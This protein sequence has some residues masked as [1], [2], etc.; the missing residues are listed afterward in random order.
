MVLRGVVLGA[1][2][3]VLDAKLCHDVKMAQ[4][5]ERRANSEWQEVD[6]V[7]RK[8]SRTIP[9]CAANL[10]VVVVVGGGGGGVG[11]DVGVDV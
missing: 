7:G 4:E 8:P 3:F 1:C 5:H 6:L 10:T 9:I 2:A 11:V